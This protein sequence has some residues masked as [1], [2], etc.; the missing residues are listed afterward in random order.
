M[1]AEILGNLLNR[2][3]VLADH[4]ARLFRDFLAVEFALRHVLNDRTDR[5]SGGNGKYADI[6][7]AVAV[8]LI[9]A[10]EITGPSRKR[11]FEKIGELNQ[12]AEIGAG[13]VAAGIISR[14]CIL[15]AHLGKMPVALDNLE[16]VVH[17]HNR[18][19][20]I[21]DQR[22][23]GLLRNRAEIRKAHGRLRLAVDHRR[24]KLA[25]TVVT[26]SA[27]IQFIRRGMFSDRFQSRDDF[28]LRRLLHFRDVLVRHLL[29]LHLRVAPET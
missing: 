3:H 6:E 5:A 22:I 1:F 25:A 20:N 11:A 19:R 10:F 7:N 16:I 8:N 26:A 15:A 18:S 14:Q 12:A 21:L 28:R 9:E 29:H 27:A 24:G 4:L 17:N 2:R 23:A 13:Q